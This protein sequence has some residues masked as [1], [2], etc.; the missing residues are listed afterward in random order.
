[1]QAISTPLIFLGS[2]AAG[3]HLSRGLQELQIYGRQAT[4][5]E[6]IFGA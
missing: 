4:V 2:A 6:I 1:M 5:S 3:S